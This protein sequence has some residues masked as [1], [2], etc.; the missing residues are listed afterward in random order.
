M[1]IVDGA[2]A[3]IWAKGDYTLSDS[4][5]M[6][7]V[8]PATKDFFTFPRD[9][10]GKAIANMAQSTGMTMTLKDVAITLDTLA[11]GGVID[12]RQTRHVR[13][14]GSYTVSMDMS[15]MGIDMSALPASISGG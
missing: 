6:I 11:D 14:S 2:Q 5:G 15:G 9:M 4:T 13:M 3:P 12:E 7:V 1:D 10:S 8:R